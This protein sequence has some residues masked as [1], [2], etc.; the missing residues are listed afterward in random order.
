MSETNTDPI[1]GAVPVLVTP[2]NDDGSIDL[3]GLR[4]Q[5]DFCIEAGSQALAFGIGS[6]SQMMTDS[7]R[8]QVWST[9]VE[10]A[11]GQIPVIA[12]PAHPSREGILALTQLAKDCGID[13][14]MIN[15]ENRK[16]DALVGLF[17]DLSEQV[18]LSL[19]VQ[20]A[21]ANAPAENLLQAAREAPHVTCM[22]IEC[23]GAP[24]KMGILVEGLKDLASRNI[25]I[26]GGSNGNA[27]PE[28]LER[29]SVGTLPHPVIIDA[30]RQ[31]CDLHAAG[32]TA[33]ADGIYYK[34]ILPLNRL[35][36]A[37]GGVG[38]GIWLHKVIFERAGIINSAYCRI[39]TNPQ[40]DWIM[41]KVWA[42]LAQSDLR[43]GKQ[44]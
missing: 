40:P 19:M 35:T 4:T 25:T 7:E 32:D 2:F 37:G 30:F 12:A 13:C 42:H 24:N 31:V 26:L 33:S 29:G 14:V 1:I 28:E 5:I 36:A 21:G 8:K 34:D 18:G 23:P 10:Q 11:K 20:D 27:L 44:L 38:G 17:R 16:G 6:E 3:D 9:A 43:I 15:P 39:N 41:E 22:K